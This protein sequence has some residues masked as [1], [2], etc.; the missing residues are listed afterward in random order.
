[1]EVKPVSVEEKEHMEA[2][3]FKWGKL[4]NQRKR[5]LKALWQYYADFRIQGSEVKVTEAELW[6]ELGCEG[7]VPK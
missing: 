7:P 6:E 5:A 1:M 3:Q 2:D 4:M